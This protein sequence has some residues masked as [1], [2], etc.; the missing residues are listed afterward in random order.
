MTSA[1]WTSQMIRVALYVRVSTSGQS[2]EDQTREL[3][4]WAERAGHEIV[5]TYTDDAISGSKGREARP[6]F[7]QALKNATRR[8]Y[9]ML[10]A[11]SVDR[12]GRSVQDLVTAL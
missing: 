6:G 10:A 11:W 2:V 5:A 1:S 12:L 8:R 7:D 4:A 9:D 3:T